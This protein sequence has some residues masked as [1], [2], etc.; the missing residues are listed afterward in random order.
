MSSKDPGIP[1]L[2]SLKARNAGKQHLQPP[3][4][5]DPDAQMASEPTLSSLAALAASSSGVDDDVYAAGPSSSRGAPKTKEQLRRHYIRALHKVIDES[6]IIILVLD[7]RDPEGCRSRLV[8]EEVRRREGEGKRLVFVLN[9]VGDLSNT[10]HLTDLVPRE[11]AQAWLRYLRHSTPTLPFKSAGSHQRSNLSSSTAPALLR[12]LK[13][14][15]PSAQSITVGIVGYPNVG[16]S[17]LINS[18]KRSK[19]CAVAA[20]P[21]H[22]KELQ[23]VQLE[24]GLKIIDSPGVVFDDDAFDDGKSQRKSNIL[25]RNVVKVEDIEDPVAIVEE[26]IA[27]TDH[28][29]LKKLYNVEDYTSPLEFLTMVALTTG[30]LLKGGTPDILAAARQILADWNHQKIP[31]FSSPPELHPSLVPSTVPGASNQVAPGAETVGQAQIVTEF[32]KPFTLDGL[33]GAAD[34]GAFADAEMADAEDT[35]AAESMDEDGKQMESDDLAP[36]IPRK[37]SRSPSESVA[38]LSTITDASHAPQAQVTDTARPPAPKRLRRS[39]EVPDYHAPVDEHARR[40]M[41]SANPLGRRVLKRE[42]KKARRAANRAALLKRAQGR[43]LGMEVD[44]DAGL[45]ATFM[46]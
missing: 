11:N 6:D 5:L 34:A 44:E 3:P 28:A 10:F 45:E 21:G 18:L 14:Y 12:L 26:I 25:L 37:R 9:K 20:Q 2:P 19:V 16:K 43:A 35:E 30:R 40:T 23:T 29:V 15:K 13:A 7:A 8:E 36:R 24:R 39:R 32:A 17:S 27:R 22:T 38:S 42:A 31:Y 46:T 33:F 1:R 41:A 4:R